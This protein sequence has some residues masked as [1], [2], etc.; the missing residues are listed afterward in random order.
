M[1]VGGLVPAA[2]SAMRCCVDLPAQ[3]C[4]AWAPFWRARGSS[5]SRR[6]SVWNSRASSVPEASMTL[7]VASDRPEVGVFATRCP[8]V[9]VCVCVDAHRARSGSRFTDVGR[10]RMVHTHALRRDI[11]SRC[12]VGAPRLRVLEAH[13]DFEGQVVDDRRQTSCPDVHGDPWCGSS[14]RRSAAHAPGRVTHCQNQFGPIW[15]RFLPI[16]GGVGQSCVCRPMLGRI[17]VS[18]RLRPISSDAG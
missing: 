15:G 3:R 5:C 4:S 18:W 17:L 8:H 11:G 14:R 2:C 12:T 6:V 10:V 1:G 9:C 7:P 13:E 16:S